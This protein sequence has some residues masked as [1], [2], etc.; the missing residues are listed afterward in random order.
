MF[1]RFLHSLSAFT[2]TFGPFSFK[3]QFEKFID[4]NYF[5]ELLFTVVS[6]HH[7]NKNNK[8]NDET[9]FSS[10]NFSRFELDIEVIM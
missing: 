7:G 3:I 5:V 8:I 9:H 1:N 4:N 2:F 10:L 6:I